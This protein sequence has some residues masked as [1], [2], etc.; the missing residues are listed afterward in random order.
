MVI[1]QMTSMQP[2]TSRSG[3][4]HPKRA[5]RH[6]KMRCYSILRDVPIKLPYPKDIITSQDH[7]YSVIVTDHYGW[8]VEDEV[9]HV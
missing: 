9:I 5:C 3:Q 8:T 2:D 4:Q 1:H 6:V 7:I